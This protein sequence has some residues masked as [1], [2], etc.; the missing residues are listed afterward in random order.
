MKL[1]LN[2]ELLILIYIF[3]FKCIFVELKSC[4]FFYKLRLDL[5]TYIFYMMVGKIDRRFIF[6]YVL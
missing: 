2:F 6:Y 4:F 1:K 3:I 5:I